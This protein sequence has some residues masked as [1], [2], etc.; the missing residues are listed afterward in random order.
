[1]FLL[2]YL[3]TKRKKMKSNP[4]RDKKRVDDNWPLH[5]RIGSTVRVD[6]TPFILAGDL[7]KA[8]KPEGDMVVK[9]AG[10]FNLAGLLQHRF[11]VQDMAN[12]ELMLQVGMKGGMVDSIDFF[13][14]LDEQ[15]PSSKEE[16]HIWLNEKD[17]FIG[18]LNFQHPD[19]IVYTRWWK[20]KGGEHVRPQLATETVIDDPYDEDLVRFNHQMM[21][22]ARD[23]T[24]DLREYCLL[25]TVEEGNE[26]A[27][28][29]YVGL[30]VEESIL[31]VL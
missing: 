22:Y 24:T 5:L 15:I 4:S 1:M 9:A 2:E 23:L 8:V 18:S 30:R 20:S 28:S 19:G 7:T 11:Y 6:E 3:K 16:W 13:H 21:M 10:Q 26:S 31:T 27:V 12:Q 14:L 17:G 29:I 25:E